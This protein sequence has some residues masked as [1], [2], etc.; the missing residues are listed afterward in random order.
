MAVGRR[1]KPGGTAAVRRRPGRGTGSK[2]SGARPVVLVLHGPN[3]NLL[4]QRE[5]QIYGTDTLAEIDAS[6]RQAGDAAGVEVRCHQSNHEGALIDLIQ[7]A[8]GTVAAVVINAGGLTHT[9]VALRDAIA[10]SE[11]PAVEVHLSNL[12]KREDFRHRS[13]LGAVCVGT[14]AGFGAMGYLLGLQAAVDI[15]RKDARTR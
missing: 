8:R 4:G 9:S 10:A 2:R 6:L 14:V 12:A 3:L 7:A 13:L 15:I 5:P 11:L 1:N